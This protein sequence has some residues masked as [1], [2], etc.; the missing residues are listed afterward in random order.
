MA[1]VSMTKAK[2]LMWG[3]VFLFFSFVIQVIT[4]MI[5]QFVVMTKPHENVVFQIHRYNGFI[6]IG[7]AIFHIVLHARVIK[8]VYFE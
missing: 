3:N 1:T 2:Y 5:L 4:S 8:Y 6:F 7:L